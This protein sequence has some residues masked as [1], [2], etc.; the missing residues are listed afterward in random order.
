MT[1]ILNQKIKN[2]MIIDDNEID[3]LIASRLILKHSFAENIIKYTDPK[4][5]LNYL[6][7]NQNDAVALPEVILLDIMMPLMTGFEFMEAYDQLDASIKKHCKVYIV[8][9][10]IDKDDIQRAQNDK[11]V[12]GFQVKPINDK[13]IGLISV[14]P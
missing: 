3:I 13:F 1:N 8:S 14:L 12:V 5:A 11:N 4:E 7:E 9:S 6:I 2:V 10:T